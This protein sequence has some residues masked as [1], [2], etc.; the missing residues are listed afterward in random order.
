MKYLRNGLI[1]AALAAFG[2]GSPVRAG[3]LV[4]INFWVSW[5]PQQMDGIAA[6]KEIAA[7]EQAH[8][9]VKIDVQNITYDALH[10]KLLTALAGGDAPDLSWGLPEWLGELNRMDALR[11]LTEEV[12]GHRQVKR[13]LS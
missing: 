6:K 5:D 7:Y 1:I 3:D 4:T 9:G 2:I 8:P 13:A 10:G 12:K 11:D